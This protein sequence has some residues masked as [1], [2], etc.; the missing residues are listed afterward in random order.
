MSLYW[1]YVMSNDTWYR[2]KLMFRLRYYWNNVTSNANICMAIGW[3][4]LYG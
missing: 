1:N 3:V 4:G 2:V